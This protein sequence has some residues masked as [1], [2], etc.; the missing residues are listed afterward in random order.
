MTPADTRAK[1]RLPLT[2]AAFVIARR[3]FTA[4]LFSKSF[5]FFLLGPL[6]F[7]GI[8]G[9]ASLLSSQAIRSADNPR[10][11]VAMAPTDSAAFASAHTRLADLV[12]L[13]DIETVEPGT[14]DDVGALLGDTEQNFGAVLSGTLAAPRLSGT[15]DRIERWRGPVALVAAEA[16]SAGAADYPQVSLMPTAT[17]VAQERSANAATATAAVT[18]LF[19]LSMLLAGMVMSNLVEEKANKIIEILAAAVPMDAVFFGKLFAMLALSF[20]G[21]AVWGG[22]GGTIALAGNLLEQMPAPAIGWPAF[23]VLFLVYFAMAYLLIGSIFLAIGSMAPTVRDVQTLSMPA[24]ILQLLVFF[25]ASYAMTD[26]GSPVELFAIAFPLSS[27]YAM[28]ARAAQEPALWPHALAIVWQIAAV[29]L[30]VRLGARLF[31]KRVMKSGP[32][33]TNKRRFWQRGAKPAAS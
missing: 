8:G 29:A 33:Q 31:R 6:F 16:G 19:L 5:L 2:R 12:D 24:T 13:P 28:I 10:L 7:L 20:V 4:I 22:V 3:D 17:S 18:L 21:I 14:V 23:A 32:A 30:F 15:Q 11:A 25:L 1:A 9:V 27:P 26:P